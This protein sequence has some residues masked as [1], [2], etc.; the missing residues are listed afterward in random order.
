[1]TESRGIR[2]LLLLL[3]SSEM[4]ALESGIKELEASGRMEDTEL[5]NGIRELEAY[6]EVN[7]S[8][9]IS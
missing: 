4:V 9:E 7:G 1:M 5:S 8:D 6:W 3:E 2:L